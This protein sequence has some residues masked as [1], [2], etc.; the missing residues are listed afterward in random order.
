[1][2][3]KMSLTLMLCA[4]V[5]SSGVSALGLGQIHPQST[6]NQNFEG[7]IDLLSVKA[8]EL[9]DVKVSLASADA[10]DKAGINRPFTLTK[11]RFRPE[12]RS[13]GST[14]IRVTSR[15]PIR[16][17]FLDFLIEVNW[18]NGKLLREFVVL[19]DPPVTLQRPPAPVA[20]PAVRP[21]RPQVQAPKVTPAETGVFQ[22]EDVVAGR[23][24]T[25]AI[26]DDLGV[27]PNA[28]R[29]VL[30]C[31]VFGREKEL[32]RIEILFERS[33]ERP[34]YMTRHRV[35]RLGLTSIPLAGPSV[36]R[37]R[38][39]KPSHDL[40]AV[41]GVAG[42]DLN[43]QPGGRMIGQLTGHRAAGLDPRRD[44]AVQ[45]VRATVANGAQHPPQPG[46]HGS[47]PIVISDHDAVVADPQLPHPIRELVQSGRGCRPG[48]FSA[49]RSASRST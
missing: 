37:D 39:S 5:V 29:P 19:L 42:V 17:P 2:V 13:D 38:R 10:F 31:Q 12:V 9:A 36:Q 30:R 47:P 28:E 43:G 23:D 45:D 24:T 1:M 41:D 48:P 49:E 21:P 22:G 7:H 33:I 27:L 44:S 15:E 25:A 3:R 8:D 16:E 6:L 40:V 46:G 4:S 14:V 20:V 11:L 18:P 35:D 32:A 26:D 34:R